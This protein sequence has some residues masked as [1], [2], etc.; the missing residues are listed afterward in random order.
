M[1][2]DLLN[3]ELKRDEFHRRL[4]GGIPTG[5]LMLIEG[6]YGYGKSIICQ[7]LAYGVLN[8]NA[9]VTYI[10]NELS[11]KDFF[12]QMDS[13]R[14]D[15]TEYILDQHLLFI[16]MFP[17]LGSVTFRKDF[18]NRLMGAEE[19]FK[20]DLIIIDTLSFILV[21]D[22]ATEKKCF[23]VIKFFKKM[24]NLEKTILFTVDSEHLNPNLLTLVRSMCDIH[25]ELGQK[26]IGGDIKRY[27]A[28]NRFK[29]SKEFVNPII[30]F[31]VEPNEGLGIEISS[32][33]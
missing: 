26:A 18:I 31:R 11:T 32:M 12:Q 27:I 17:L 14:Y 24:A 16:P 21:Q 7:R 10:S 25:F 8:H 3:I 28:V 23:E 9:K 29:R 2:Q 1:G 20:N 13:V 30:P 15:V 4:G 33:I 6:K 22:N 5:S 19:L